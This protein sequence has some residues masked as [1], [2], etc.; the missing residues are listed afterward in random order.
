MGLLA[1]N[2]F[3]TSQLVFEWR[4]SGNYSDLVM[5][6]LNDIF[7]KIDQRSP[8]EK[9]TNYADFKKCMTAIFDSVD[10]EE[11]VESVQSPEDYMPGLLD[12]VTD[13]YVRAKSA[14]KEYPQ[15]DRLMKDSSK[16]RQDKDRYRNRVKEYTH[17]AIGRKVP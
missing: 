17:Y 6:M 9:M 8:Y 13:R 5:K 10:E 4:E 7:E 3:A 2:Y 14:L 12:F 1:H 15:A 16:I 11:E